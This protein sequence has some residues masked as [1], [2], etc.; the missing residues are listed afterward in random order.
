[1]WVQ[2]INIVNQFLL[3][4]SGRSQVQFL[5]GQWICDVIR[6]YLQ[7]VTKMPYIHTQNPKFHKNVF[8]KKIS[9]FPILLITVVASN[10]MVCLL[11][12]CIWERWENC[13][14]LSHLENDCDVSAYS[15]VRR[16]SSR[17]QL[18]CF[19]LTHS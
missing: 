18:V 13:H 6:I 8:L 16:L 12:L 3:H 7:L 15:G 9:K 2:L 17:E 10:Q 4:H 1:M 11:K 19:F 5:I 14:T